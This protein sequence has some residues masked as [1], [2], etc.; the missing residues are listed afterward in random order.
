VRTIKRCLFDD[1]HGLDMVIRMKASPLDKEGNG[2]GYRAIPSK[3]DTGRRGAD[4]I[5]ICDR[6]D[7][8]LEREADGVDFPRREVRREDRFKVVDNYA[9]TKTAGV[10]VRRYR[11]HMIFHIDGRPQ[12]KKIVSYVNGKMC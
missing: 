9:C 1:C 2:R 5:V 10:I 4:G 3:C 11:R 8:R 12:F 6:C 7:E